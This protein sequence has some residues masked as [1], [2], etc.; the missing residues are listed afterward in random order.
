MIDFLVYIKL[1]S[2]ATFARQ[3]IYDGSNG[4]QIKALF[5]F[6]YFHERPRSHRLWPK[7]IT[8]FNVDEKSKVFIS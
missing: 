7:N 8:D 2:L 5:P 4:V 6:N 3:I 1:D